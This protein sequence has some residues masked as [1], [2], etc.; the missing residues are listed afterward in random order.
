MALVDTLATVRYDSKL[1]PVS[2]IYLQLND[3]D[4][5]AFDKAVEKGISTNGLLTA[6]QKEGYAI[7]WAS[8]EKHLNKICKC[9]K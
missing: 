4:R 5:N 7:S 6:L 2:S 3:E 9:A 1:C 8:I